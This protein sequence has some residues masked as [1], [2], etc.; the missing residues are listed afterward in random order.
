[1][2]DVLVAGE[3]VVVFGAGGHARAVADVLARLPVAVAAVVDPAAPAPAL[4]SDEEGLRLARDRGLPAV[5]A[6][7]DN[8]R[9]LALAQ[10][11]AAAGI[12]LP[13]VVATTATVAADAA[14]G[15]A[16]VVLEHA[17]VGAGAALGA[18]CVVNTA[19]VVEHDCALGDGVH[20]APGSVLT[21]AV[22][23]G[24]RV[25]VGAGAVALPGVALDA[26]AVA[27]AGS[28]VT[29]AVAAGRTVAG[30]P[31]REIGGGS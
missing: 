11:L 2:P 25:V 15:A 9:R 6:I 12:A 18:A 30:V 31:A 1:M 20:C 8:R 14:L 29:A 4:R 23:C 3:T 27:G 26:D 21:G 5:V 10:R 28:V 7:G 16:T 22:R 13:A 24:D 19:A 17:H